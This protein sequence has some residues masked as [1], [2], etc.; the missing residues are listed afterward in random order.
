[1]SSPGVAWLFSPATRP[2]RVLGAAASADVVVIDLEDGVAPSERESAR[3]ELAGLRAALDPA[4]AVVRV[5]PVG[6]DDHARDLAALRSAGFTT[7]M[8]SKAESAAEVESL[9]DVKVVALC[10][11]P[12]G[13]AAA[14]AIAAAGNCIGLM[15]G[16]EDLAVSLGASG[17]RRDGALLPVLETARHA[18]LLAARAAGVIAIDAVYPHVAD[19]GGLLAEARDAARSGFDGKACIHPSQLEPVRE[20]FTPSTEQVANASQIV[21]AS[22]ASSGAFLLD[23]RMVDEPIVRTALRVLERARALDRRLPR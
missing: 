15:W 23:G 9:H 11:T 1:V 6:T 13:I 19:T 4:A 21:R 8:L 5:N 7:C 17:S 12:R 20:A 10:E 16:S 22:E 3:R 14:A 2:D 18:V